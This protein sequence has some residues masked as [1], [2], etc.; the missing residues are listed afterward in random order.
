MEPICAHAFTTVYPKNVSKLHTEVILHAN[1][2]ALKCLALWDTGATNSAIAHRVSADLGM[3][4][5]G[6][7]NV[8]TPSG[9]AHY[10]TYVVDLELNNGPIISDL[11][12]SDSEISKQGID[13]LIGMDVISQGDFAV[14]NA[15]GHTVFT[16]RIP[17]QETVDF[18]K[19]AKVQRLLKRGKSPK[20]N[21]RS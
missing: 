21:K 20:K 5:C 13:I 16:F 2:S 4:P 1:G 10:N 9:A 18:V 12:V 19:K 7:V 11:V 8:F 17:A 14:S 6:I 3:I 15:H